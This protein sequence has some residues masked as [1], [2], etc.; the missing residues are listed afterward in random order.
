MILHVFEENDP[1]EQANHLEF[2]FGYPEFGPHYNVE[3]MRQVCYCGASLVTMERDNQ[4]NM[5]TAAIWHE[6]EFDIMFFT[7]KEPYDE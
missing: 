7:E 5:L 3:K 1:E 6:M 2:W 4:G